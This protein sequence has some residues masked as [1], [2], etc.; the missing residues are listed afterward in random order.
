MQ[1]FQFQSSSLSIV[2]STGFSLNLVGGWLVDQPY[3]KGGLAIDFGTMRCW[4]A[5]HSGNN[6]AGIFG[7]QLPAMGSGT[8]MQAWPSV[9]PS[10]NYGSPYFAGGSG[11]QLYTTGLMYRDGLLWVSGKEFY[12]ASGGYPDTVIKKFSLS[13]SS[14]TLAGTLTFAGKPMQAFGG[15]FIKGGPQPLIGCGGYESGQGC[16]S[17]PCW[18]DLAGNIINEFPDF[19][20]YA[21]DREKRDTNYS[22]P[23]QDPYQWFTGPTGGVG[24]WCDGRI[25]GGGL[26]INGFTCFFAELGLGLCRYEGGGPVHH[27]G[28]ARYIYKYA[29][30]EHFG[31]WEPFAYSVPIGQDINGS[32][33]YLLIDRV[34]SDAR[35]AIAVFEIQ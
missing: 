16:R 24:Y 35:P 7:Y 2:P 27:G 26:I 5:G 17:G 8:N 3:C 14:T 13:G 32:Y 19:A 31:T 21:P 29:P 4:T 18:M 23:S 10:W 6:A 22:T 12:T 20:A 28:D 11:L 9:V 1:S 33:V 34:W 30:G 15:G 25:W